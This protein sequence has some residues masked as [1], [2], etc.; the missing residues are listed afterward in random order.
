MY[1]I[2]VKENDFKEIHKIIEE[3]IKHSR[4]KSLYYKY[5]ILKIEHFNSSQSIL[6]ILY[7]C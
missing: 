7:L 2:R 6:T 1:R 3:E 5:S 4:A